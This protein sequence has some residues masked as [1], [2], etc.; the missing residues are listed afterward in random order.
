MK[1]NIF[2]ILIITLSTS[3]KS[4]YNSDWAHNMNRSYVYGWGALGGNGQ[5]SQRGSR[6]QRGYG[7]W[8]AGEY[9]NQ[10]G[11]RGLYY[12]YGASQKQ[13]NFMFLGNAGYYY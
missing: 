10:R 7:H 11:Y 13:D 9:N 3:I 6:I 5:H 12:P 4:Y 2:L 1:L 8:G